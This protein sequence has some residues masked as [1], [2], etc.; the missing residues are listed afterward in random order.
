[1][2]VHW[3]WF[4]TRQNLSDREKTALLRHFQDPEAL[5][6][7]T[8][9]D[10][11]A[12]SLKEQAMESLLDKDLLG[13]EAILADCMEKDIHI[14]T[15]RDAGYPV[16]LKNIADPP[17]VLYY[18]GQLPDID[19]LPT[20]SLV[21]TRRA[22]AYGLSTAKRMGYQLAKCGAVVIS[23]VAGGIDGA[24]ATGALMAGGTVVG[25]LGCGA[26]VVYPAHHRGLYTDIQHHGCLLTEFPP[27]TP[28]H[29]WNF[30]KRNRILSGLGCGTLVVEAPRISGALIT[31]RLALDQGRDVFVVP[32]N[33]DVD[34]FV[35]SNALLK[36]G[37][38]VASC[39]WDVMEQY[40]HL[41][42]GKVRCYTG[43]TR[44]GTNISSQETPAMV[45]EQAIYPQKSP[46]SSRKTEK[47]PIDKE[48]KSPY[49]GIQESLSGEQQQIIKALEAGACLV[50]DLVAKTGMTAS[51]ILANLTMLQISGIVE[52]KPGN[53]VQLK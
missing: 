38:M 25:V 21:G 45:A 49:H 15:Y 22:S 41:Y 42:P 1:M 23:G 13:A 33:I 12:L 44:I 46:V 51:E 16:K 19:N 18:K 4:S 29:K 7:A 52:Q 11:K 48:A 9:A 43:S 40:A 47:K 26:D 10:L 8:S 39:G 6:Y 3:I 34:T 30:P 31:A 50:D 35:G 14:C 2:L 28:P 53:R 27:G 17:M 36:E 32:G 37:A 24:G 5:F 20:V